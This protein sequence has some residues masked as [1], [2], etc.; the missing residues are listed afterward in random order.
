MLLFIAFET[1]KPIGREIKKSKARE[2]NTANIFASPNRGVKTTS[3]EGTPKVL[4]DNPVRIDLLF[5]GK[6]EF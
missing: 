4:V 3:N 1:P 5:I 2:K 6:I